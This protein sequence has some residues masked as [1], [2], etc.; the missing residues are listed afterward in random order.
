MLT[1]ENGMFILKDI[2]TGYE[3][4]SA[5]FKG[6]T[7]GSVAADVGQGEGNQEVT[8]YLTKGNNTIRFD[9]KEIVAGETVKLK[10]IMFELGKADL[11]AG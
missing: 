10:N 8:F 1:D 11:N 9:N 2:P 5:S 7:D 6:Y 3:I 4:I